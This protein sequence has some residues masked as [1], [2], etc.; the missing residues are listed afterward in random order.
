VALCAKAAAE[1][2]RRDDA[3]LS[4][5]VRR[6]DSIAQRS[7]EIV[8]ELHIAL[9]SWALDALVPQRDE[10]PWPALRARAQRGRRYGL[11]ATLSAYSAAVAGHDQPEELVEALLAGPTASPALV[12]A[13]MVLWLLTV[14]TERA[15]RFVSA[16]EPGLRTLIDRRAQLVSRLA[17][18]L[19]ESAFIDPA[20]G[21][22][23]P[24][25]EADLTPRA[26]L[27]SMDTLLL[28]L[29][30]AT[31]EAEHPYLSMTEARDLFGRSVAEARADE[32]RWIAR[33]AGIITLC[34]PLL[35]ATTTLAAIL[36]GAP[37]GAA[38]WGGL[39]IAALPVLIAVGLW[40]RAGEATLTT[41][42]ASLA[43]TF[44]VFGCLAAINSAVTH[45]FL[46][47]VLGVFTGA[48]GAAVVGTIVA[49][50]A[51]GAGGDRY[52]SVS[53]PL[54]GPDR[55]ERRAKG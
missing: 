1:L 18:E 17:T 41:P 52:R 36:L 49:V 29:A 23:H 43:A 50:V 12:D 22:F 16:E 21:D 55:H 20:I 40:Q 14:G 27:S 7:T 13:P 10:A 39:T 31:P 4:D 28:D 8:P 35:G 5:A 25:E 38:V 26:Y 6:V 24:D 48:V 37:S 33:T 19:D 9:C 42:L 11:D 46:P 44:A 54:I 32:R 3:L 34:G 51:R 2:A 15:S 30:L 47:D 53:L 45:P